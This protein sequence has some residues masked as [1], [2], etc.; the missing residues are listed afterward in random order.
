MSAPGSPSDVPSSSDADGPPSQDE[1]SAARTH[2]GQGAQ[3]P[4]DASGERGSAGEIRAEALLL[5]RA[6]G[7]W[8]GLIDS[9]VPT[10]VFVGGYALPG[11]HLTEAL[12]AALSAGAIIAG[13][14]V[15]RRQ[16]LQQV[17]AGLA[18]LGIAALVTWRTGRAEDFFL[19]GFLTNAAYGLAFLVSIVIRWPLLGV[20]MGLL[21]GSGTSWRRD[22]SLYRTYAAASWL[23]VG[24]F[25]LRLAVQVPLYLAGAVSALGTARIVLGTP[26]FALAAYLSYRLLAPAYARARGSAAD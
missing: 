7:G 21:T 15:L 9:A 26:L 22:R 20:V 19:P 14:R 8:R 3:S 2:E 13:I 12:I 11:Q 18:G 4:A 10:A 23:W 1:A 5:E 6:I 17:A 24:V 25:G 16:P